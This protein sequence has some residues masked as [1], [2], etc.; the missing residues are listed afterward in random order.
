MEQ[1]IASIVMGIGQAA[2]V[3][4]ATK[5]GRVTISHGRQRVF[6]DVGRC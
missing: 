3:H 2:K 1:G 6:K 4:V 5:E